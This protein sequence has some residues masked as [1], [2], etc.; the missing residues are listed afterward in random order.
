MYK[1]L[2]DFDIIYLGKFCRSREELRELA[3]PANFDSFVYRIDDF[4]VP[5]FEGAKNILEFIERYV[6]NLNLDSN[7]DIN[8]LDMCILP[9]YVVLVLDDVVLVLDE[10]DDV[11]D[12]LVLVDV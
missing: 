10:L 5:D 9:Y 2:C 11:L 1:L 8:F 12:V 4:F 7:P 3:H 6:W